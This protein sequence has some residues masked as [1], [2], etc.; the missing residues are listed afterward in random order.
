L[1]DFNHYKDGL[2]SLAKLIRNTGKD[3]AAACMQI[4]AFKTQ[5]G[6]L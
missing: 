1:V 5:L 2:L 6:P 4:A 3:M